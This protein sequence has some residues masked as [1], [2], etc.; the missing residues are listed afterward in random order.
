MA[1]KK[2]KVYKYTSPNNKYYIGQTCQS[3]T[4]RANQGQGY[5]ESPKFYN[6]IKKY[7]FENFKVEILKDNLTLEEANYWQTY[8]IHFYQTL[9]DEYGYNLSTGGSNPVPNEQTRQKMR[10]SRLGYIH[11]EQTKEKIRK[12]HLNKN[13]SEQHKQHLSQT[14]KKRE[15]QGMSGKHHSD[16][17]KKKIGR[18][19]SKPVLC[20]ETNIIYPSAAQACRQLGL[21]SNH[22]N[23]CINNPDRYKTV[24]GYHW[25]RYIQEQEEKND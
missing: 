23:D 12:S 9:S 10:Q 13:F 4:S 25:K 20:I 7:G 11:S 1:I 24:G 21:K 3:L 16:Q 18:K 6:A 14:A 19:N 2:Y 22:I 5:K 17:T 15:I 8:Y